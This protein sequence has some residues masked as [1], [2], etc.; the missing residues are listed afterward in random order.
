MPAASREVEF[1]RMWTGIE[2]K[3]KA[4]GIGL[5][6]AGSDLDGEWSVHSVDAGAEYVAAVAACRTGITVQ[7][8]TLTT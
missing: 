8:R 1:F 4:R 3:L 6:G 7:V 2:A 5:Y